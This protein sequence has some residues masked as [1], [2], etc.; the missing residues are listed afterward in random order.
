MKYQGGVREEGICP[1]V[2]EAGE[3]ACC[4]DAAEDD[5][6]YW[7]WEREPTRGCGL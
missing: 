2:H 5:D 4:E 7:S 6:E 3:R 1:Q